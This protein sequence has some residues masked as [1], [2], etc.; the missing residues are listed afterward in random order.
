MKFSKFNNPRRKTIR[1]TS[2]YSRQYIEEQKEQLYTLLAKAKT[3]AE[4]DAL[5][6]AYN[7]TIHPYREGGYKP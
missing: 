7:A 5:I 1:K 4:K 2:P 3:E 6:K